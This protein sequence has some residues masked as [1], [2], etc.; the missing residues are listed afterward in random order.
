M[1]NCTNLFLG[2]SMNKQDFYFDLPSELIAQYPLANRSDSRLLIY[3]R[4][5]EEYGHYQFREIADFLQPGDLLVMNDSKV[6]PARLYG[7][8]ATGG[9]VELLV[10]RIT[11]DFTFLAHIKASKSLKS[12]DLIYLDAGKRLEVLER[13]D[14]LFLCK[15][16]ENILDLLN[17]LGHIPL[18]PYIARED[19]SLDK[20]RY[21]TVYAKCAGSVAAPTAG[22]HF[23]DAVLSSIRAR[24]VN[25]AYVTLHVG[26][27]TFRPVRCERIQDHKM[28]SEWFTVSPDLCSAVK[29]AKSMGN[30]VIAVGTTALRSLE[31]AAMGGE[32]IPCSRDTDIFIYPGYQFKVCDGL[33]TNFHLPEST[34]VMLV[35]AFIGHQECMA[36]YQEAIDKRYRFFSYGDASLLL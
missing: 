24:G 1:Y 6:I 28:H 17:D 9:K 11:G 12:N 15:A 3:N 27:G 35:S 2:C 32:L 22:L 13:Q 19:E 26:A 4:Q 7:H 18:P 31:S 36:L 5:T 16:S 21:Q 20:E 8:K 33:I 23:D 14:D 25:I 30:R 10:E 29:A 34:L